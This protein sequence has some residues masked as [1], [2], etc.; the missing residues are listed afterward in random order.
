MINIKNTAEIKIMRKV[1]RI[2]GQILE[3]VGQEVAPG[4]T[5]AYLNDKAEELCRQHN[6]KPAFKGYR[7]YPYSLCC[8][9]N[10]QVVHGFP[11][12]QFP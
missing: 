11:S 7:G 6:A 12:P 3:A 4:V 5:T 9:V 10:D 8:S 2:V 1:N